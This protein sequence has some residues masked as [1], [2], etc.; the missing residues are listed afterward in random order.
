MLN[1]V[2]PTMAPTTN[3]DDDDD[4]NVCKPKCRQWSKKRTTTIKIDII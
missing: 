3:R 4:D 2:M 1:K